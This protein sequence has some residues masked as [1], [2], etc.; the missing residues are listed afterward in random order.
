MHYNPRIQPVLLTF[1]GMV[2][3]V[4][5]C[6]I[7]AAMT[8]LAFAQGP[9]GSIDGFVRDPTGAAIPDATIQVINQSTSVPERT[10]FSSND[11]HFAALLLPVGT[12]R[13]IVNAPK[14]MNLAKTNARNVEV[15]VAETTPVVIAMQVGAVTEE[16]TVTGVAAAVKTTDAATGEVISARSVSDLPL[17]T[18][19]F[20]GLLQVTA[21]TGGEIFDSAALGRGQVT[22]NVNGQRPSNNNYELEGIPANDFNLPLLD[23]VALPNPDAIQEFKAQ[24]SLYDASQ[25]RN[26]GANVQVNLKSGS[27]DWHG[28]AFDFYRNDKLNANSWFDKRSEIEN[29][30]STRQPR[31]HQQQYGGTLGGPVPL[32]KD[33]FVFGSYQGTRASSAASTGTSISTTMVALPQTRDAA[34]LTSIFFPGGIAAWAPGASLDPTVLALL[35]VPASKCP[36]FND[37]T[38]CIPSTGTPG[39]VGTPSTSVTPSVNTGDVVARLNGTYDENQFAITSDKSIGNNDKITARFFWDNFTTVS[40]FNL[41][42]NSTLPFSRDQPQQNRFAKIGWTRTFGTSVVNDFKFGFNR[43]KWKFVPGEPITAAEIGQ[44]RPNTD[45]FPAMARFAVSG[46]GAFSIGTGQNDDRTTVQNGFVYGDDMAV[47]KGKHQLRFGVEIDQ[48]QLNRQN[49]FST[50]GSMTFAK[51]S[52]T[53]SVGGSGIV[54]NGVQNLLLGRII[55]TQAGGGIT[56]YYFRARDYGTYFQDDWKVHPRLTLNLGLRWEFLSTANDKRGFQTNWRFDTAVNPPAVEIHPASYPGPLATPGVSDCTQDSC[57]YKKALEPRVGFA[58]DVLGNQKTVVR[59]GFG[60]YYTRVSN[61]ANLQTT[62]GLPFQLATSA[63]KFTV[64]PENPVPNLIPQSQFPLTT[65]DVVPILTSFDA[66]TGAP[67]FNSASGGPFSAFIFQPVRNLVPP[68]TLQYNLGVQREF[69]KNWTMEL[70]YVGTRGV[71]LLGPGGAQNFS[72]YCNAAKPCVIPNSIAQ[73]VTVPVDTPNVVKNADGSIFITGS[74]S[75]N[76]NA[77]VPARF[78]GLAENH[79]FGQ[80]NAG[81][82]KY[83][84]LQATVLHQFAR[85]LYFQGAYTYSHCIDNGSGSQYGDELNGLLMFGDETNNHA[86]QGNCDFDR[87]HHL[88]VSW[89]YDLPLERWLNIGNHGVGKIVSGWAVNGVLTWQSGTPFGLFDSSTCAVT[90]VNCNNGVNFATYATGANRN[91]AF[92][93]TADCKVGTIDCWINPAAFADTATGAGSAVCLDAQ[94][95]PDPTCSTGL[96][97]QGNVPRNIYRG[98]RQSNVDFSLIK[99]TKIRE[100]MELQ[101]RWEAFNVFNHPAFAGPAAGGQGSTSGNYGFVDVSGDS[102]PILPTDHVRT[103]NILRT[104]NRPRIMQL[105]V[106]FT[107]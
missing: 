43:F 41:A 4:V 27:K 18:R 49:N 13:L 37:G 84:S 5:L 46:S 33:W 16:V 74:T 38:F 77:R 17:V 40:P 106:K 92:V 80:L 64:T 22:L 39:L 8:S 20:F 105:A 62:G 100:K 45:Q 104:A 50:R 67:I 42:S 34:T 81:Y 87:T 48:Y 21:G 60:I 79:Y 19:N 15:R 95:N 61:Q 36:G 96:F 90:D 53:D 29:G 99:T 72:Q 31:L 78:L 52:T 24:T 85:G 82:S 47:T 54:L 7:V 10:V 98:P 65:G 89:N 51:T 93:S 73:N 68:H 97:A 102:L 107:F 55:S 3:A 91:T 44:I 70:S 76:A 6:A 86:P 26:G 75:D 35:N 69:L 11:G 57:V 103:T 59:G 58:W 71:N 30:E 9:R 2:F 94:L 14:G 66:T 28:S 12:Y 101:L 56:T 25:G 83:D 23:N 32:V 63:A 88:A 1:R